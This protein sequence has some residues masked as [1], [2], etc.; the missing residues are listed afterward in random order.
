MHACWGAKNDL[1]KYRSYCLETLSDSIEVG[2]MLNYLL[3]P[4]EGHIHD[5]KLIDVSDLFEGDPQPS[6]VAATLVELRSMSK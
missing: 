5:L 3:G 4:L 2:Q 1:L 6:W